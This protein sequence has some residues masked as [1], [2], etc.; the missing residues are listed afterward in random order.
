[1]KPRLAIL[2]LLVALSAVPA[3]AQSCAMCYSTA[4]A[5]NKEGQNAITRG[6]VVLL[7]PPIGFMTVGVGLALRY[8]KKRDEEA[9]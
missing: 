3:F 2:G 9:E 4:R 8:G 5:L 1:M 6:V 7:I